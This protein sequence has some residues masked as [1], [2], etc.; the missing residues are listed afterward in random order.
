MRWLMGDSVYRRREPIAAVP[1]CRCGIRSHTITIAPLSYARARAR[2]GR[3]GSSK[4]QAPDRIR[5][6]VAS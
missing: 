5:F 3:M 1:C 2:D 6:V 4:M